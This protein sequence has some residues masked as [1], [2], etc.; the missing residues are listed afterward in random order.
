[1]NSDLIKRLYSEIDRIPIFDP[2]THISH[3][4]PTAR[5]LGEILSYHYYTELCNSAERQSEGWWSPDLSPDELVIRIA[6]KLPLIANTVQYSWFL[7]VGETFLGFSRDEMQNPEKLTSLHQLSK[8]IMEQP[9]YRRSVL[10]KSNIKRI[11]LTNAYTEKLDSLDAE[12]FRPCLR[13]DPLSYFID[14][15]V[16]NEIGEQANVNIDG[17]RSFDKAVESVFTRFHKKKFAYPS[18]SAWPNTRIYPVDAVREDAIIRKI[19]GKACLSEHEL[20]DHVA[21]C[22]TLIAGLCN[23]FQV[24]FHLMIGVDKNVYTHGVESGTD[25][26]DSANSLRGYDYLF[27]TYPGVSFPTSVLSDTQGLEL[28]SAAWIR[29][30]VF[31]SGHWWYLNN[32]TDIRREVARRLEVVPQHK[33]IGYYS[34][35]YYLEFVLPKFR[36]YKFVL[37][38]VL[39]ERIE[40]SVIAPN[41]PILTEDSALLVAYDL[42]WNNPRTI[43][44]ESTHTLP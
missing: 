24:P 9:D 12:L 4:A 2:H 11:Y 26:V 39:A 3:S 32:P 44:N 31:P 14:G 10:E 7:S 37:A 29:H 6:G 21:Y 34:D 16:L 23:R 36:M 33:L 18:V 17:S 1:M 42:L 25:L 35:A 8:K 15:N 28:T 20:R 5:S 40:T 38:Q 30:N 43:F 22:F 19:S 41:A 27:N 13:I